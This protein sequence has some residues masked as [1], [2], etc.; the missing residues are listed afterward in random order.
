MPEIIGSLERHGHLR[1]GSGGYGERVR[2]ELLEVSAAT[3]DR[4]LSPW[5]SGSTS[6]SALHSSGTEMR[7]A[8]PRKGLREVVDSEPGYFIVEITDGPSLFDS[9]STERPCRLMT[10]TDVEIGWVQTRAFRAGTPDAEMF[11]QSV[12]ALPY[13]VTGVLFETS[14]QSSGID[15][16]A[17]DHRIE[18]HRLGSV[19]RRLRFSDAHRSD[20][21]DVVRASPPGPALEIVDT[22]WQ[23]LALRLNHFTPVKSPVTWKL[24]SDGERRRVYDSPMT[25]VSRLISSGILSTDQAE[26]MRTK[27]RL[28]DISELTATIDDAS[29]RLATLSDPPLRCAG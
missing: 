14:A 16:W 13:I 22:L 18:V 3:I 7:A 20:P 8:L 12:A 24:T 1:E 4:Y 28:L 27:S 5:K 29:A 15:A 17:H 26:E 21:A 19:G 2:G 11:A 10:F 6:G 9:D 23:A 25:P